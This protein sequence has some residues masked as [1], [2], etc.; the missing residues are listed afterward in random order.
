M[1]KVN[2]AVNTND[3]TVLLTKIIQVTDQSL[4][5]HAKRVTVPRVSIFLWKHFKALN[6]L[7]T[8]VMRTWEQ[9]R[10]FFHS[11]ITTSNL[12]TCSSG[13]IQ[14]A[15]LTF[16]MPLRNL[17]WRKQKNQNIWLIRLVSSIKQIKIHKRKDYGNYLPIIQSITSGVA[18]ENLQTVSIPPSF[19]WPSSLTNT[20]E[21]Q[22][23]LWLDL[24]WQL[25]KTRSLSIIQACLT[26]SN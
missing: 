9:K 20:D 8:C 17:S 23:L 12:L 2:T 14:L 21:M 16:W 1:V 18:S 10:K 11:S 5:H 22:T 3:A 6:L 26:W 7:K 15:S 25:R 13:G 19:Q 4:H 24:P